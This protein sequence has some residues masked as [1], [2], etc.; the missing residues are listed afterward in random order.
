VDDNVVGMGGDT[1]M[2]AQSLGDGV[3]GGRSGTHP[4]RMGKNRRN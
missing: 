2:M 3:W 1:V 4:R